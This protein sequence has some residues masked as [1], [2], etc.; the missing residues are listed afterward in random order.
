MRSG[1]KHLAE[2][3]T[4]ATGTDADA[5]LL[6]MGLLRGSYTMEIRDNGMTA[7]VGTDKEYAAIHEFGGRA[8]R[9]HRVPVPERAHA[10]PSLHESEEEVKREF[11]EAVMKTFRR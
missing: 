11:A 10:R 5:P 9:G 3:G 8:G 1:V 7:V 2:H 6:D 4:W